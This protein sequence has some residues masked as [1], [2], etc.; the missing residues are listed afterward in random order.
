M[1]ISDLRIEVPEPEPLIPP[2][3]FDEITFESQAEV[4]FNALKQAVIE[5]ATSAPKDHD[6]L[7]KAFDLSVYEVRYLE[8]HT[9]MFR[10][11]NS[12]GLDTFAIAHYTQLVAHVIYLPKRGNER[13]V[14]GFQKV[15]SVGRA[16]D[17]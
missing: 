3:L 14:T 11:V 17:Q 1:N 7:I 16:E 5:L 10:G 15:T 2:E 9:L 13:V 4:T 12:Q 8:P 6:V